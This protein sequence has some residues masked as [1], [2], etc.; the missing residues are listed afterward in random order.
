MSAEFQTYV[1]FIVSLKSA[2]DQQLQDVIDE[3]AQ[4][5]LLGSSDMMTKIDTSIDSVFDTIDGLAK[6]LEEE[7]IADESI[8]LAEDAAAVAA[9]WSFGLS[10]V[11]FAALT[12]TDLAL[13]YFIEKKE[14]DLNN[15]LASADKDIAEGVGGPCAKYIHLVKSNNNF[16]KASS[17]N[18]LT[19]QTARNY[20]YNFMDYLSRNGGVTLTNFRKYIEVARLTN[21]NANISKI[22]DILDKLYLSDDHGEEKIKEALQGIQE[23][24]NDTSI[25]H[26]VR[27]AIMIIWMG[28]KFSAWKITRA[29]NKAGVPIEEVRSLEAVDIMGKAMATFTIVIS[30]A[31]AA[32]NIYNIVKTVD[33]YHESVKMYGEAREQYKAF[34]KQLH[35]AS[36]KYIAKNQ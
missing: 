16:I 36:A 33:R 25:L 3:R 14:E 13:Q 29:A 19:P 35:D 1:N 27:A 18:G 8:Q 28:L 30:I 22:Y 11:A 20:L 21:D 23:T 24:L 9:I 5:L 7:E 2:T 34:Y 26:W 31:D 6:K 15:H 4:F 32:L 10:M 17:P 12:A